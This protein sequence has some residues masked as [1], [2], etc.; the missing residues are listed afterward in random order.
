MCLVLNH[1]AVPLLGDGLPNL[2]S[3]SCRLRGQ[4]QH[5]PSRGPKLDRGGRYSV[6]GTYV[7]SDGK[8][9]GFAFGSIP[10]ILGTQPQD[11]LSLMRVTL[12]DS[13]RFS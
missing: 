11:V 9:T 4:A 1:P 6:L 13:S 10:P 7:R 8:D 2:P 5:L 3:G 12:L